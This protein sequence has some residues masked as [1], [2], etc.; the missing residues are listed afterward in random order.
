MLFWLAQHIQ[1]LSVLHYLSLRI[2]L[3]A[4][5]A[6]VSTICG[7]KKVIQLLVNH[8]MK[9][10]IRLYGPQEHLNK[11][12]VPTMGGILIIA[13]LTLG[14]LFGADLSNSYIW[15][16][17]FTVLGFGFIG[18]L[19]D[20]L[21]IAKQN[22]DGLSARQKLAG[23]IVVAAIIA[24]WLWRGITLSQESALIVPFFKEF[25]WQ[26]GCLFP[27]WVVL[28]MVS[29]SNA[30]N[31]TDGLDGLAIMPIVLITAALGVFSYIGGHSDFAS[32]LLV[33]YIPKLAEVAVF[34]SALVG[35]G[36]GF[37]WFNAYPAQLFMGDVGSLSLGAAIG[38]IAVLARQ[39]LVFVLMAGIPVI[40]T[41]S[42][43]IQI[44]SRRYFN[45]KVFYMA[46]FHHH[47]EFLGWA[48][49]KIIV[50]FWIITCVL[51]LLG[52]ATLKIR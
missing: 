40:E 33:P 21:K 39:E 46:P 3:A 52:L 15:Y 9:Q 17:W 44:I 34:C 5:I 6:L 48:E 37:L 24:F 11:A 14:V 1:A 45:K 25:S 2:I 32:Y 43:I 28:V 13:A 38:L 27:F 42:V 20:Y 23:Q 8:R 12:G 4:L 29:S 49:P 7:G 50:R 31:L 22:V 41:L 30:I 35:A 47:L 19:D 16:L 36:L 18:W 26:L 51:V 10:M